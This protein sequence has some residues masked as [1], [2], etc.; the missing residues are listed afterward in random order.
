MILYRADQREQNTRKLLS[1]QFYSA[2]EQEAQ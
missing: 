2:N 1:S